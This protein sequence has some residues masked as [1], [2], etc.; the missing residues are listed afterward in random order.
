MQARELLVPLVVKVIAGLSV[1]DQALNPPPWSD[2]RAASMRTDW[3]LPTPT[4][5][6]ALFVSVFGKPPFVCSVPVQFVEFGKMCST[7]VAVVPTGRTTYFTFPSVN[8]VVAV[9]EMS[10]VA[11]TLYV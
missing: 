2:V 5:S 9:P 4:V 11:V 3:V 8:E 6:P 10:P 1:L 7:N